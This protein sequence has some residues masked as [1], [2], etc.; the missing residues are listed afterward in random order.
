MKKIAK[1]LILVIAVTSLFFSC[2]TKQTEEKTEP[3]APKTEVTQKEEKVEEKTE[4]KKT[5]KK[6]PEKAPEDPPNV[7]F[8]KELQKL[9]KENN[10]A[11]AIELFNSIPDELYADKDMKVLY[12]SLLMSDKQLE[13]AQEIADELF[14]EYPDDT[15]VLELC[16]IIAL[17]RGD[18]SKQKTIN[19]QILK[20]DP[21]NSAVNIQMGDS[22]ASNKKYKQALQYYKKALV[23]DS[24][25]SD[26]LFGAGK[27]S[28]YNDDVK[29]AKA[30]FEKILV[31][32]PENAGA[33]AYLGKL[34]Y[35]EENYLKATEYCEAALK[36]E[37]Y[38]YDYRLDLGTYY[39]YLGRYEE[40]IE[41]WKIATTIDP[42]YFLAYAYLAGELDDE[43]KFQEALVYYHKVIETNPQY[44]YAY[45]ST[46]ILEW[47]EKNWVEARNYFTKAWEISGK[48]DSSYALMIAATYWKQN[49]K[50][51]MKKFLTQAMKLTTDKESVDYLML[52]FYNDN[53]V[54]AAE[55]TLK[56]N[57]EKITTTNKKGK[58]WYYLGL[59]YEMSGTTEVA[60]EWYTKVAA[61]QAP[62]FFEYRLAEWSL[63]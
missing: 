63:Q 41:Q 60:N 12:A 24:D 51:N 43:G 61:L 36:S 4:E 10:R 3:E 52:R 7:K 2:G 30:Y 55:T 13:K 29:S 39:R 46:A 37:P 50:V 35:D 58:M 22:Y 15:E 21:Y 54:K 8:A 5:S 49:D 20:S 26:A 6:E 44:W 27:M 59:Y 32:D 38:N 28:F 40:C 9:L 14:A 62:M 18:S 16:S 56:K 34:Y 57:I 47:H 19:N 31:K 45:E 53:Y 33:L 17:A 48:K 23:K 1:K 11:G 42:D 25:N